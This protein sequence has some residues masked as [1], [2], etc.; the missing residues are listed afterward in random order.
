M[1]KKEQLLEKIDK[2]IHI[3][4]TK[5]IK[6]IGEAQFFREFLKVYDIN[7]VESYSKITNTSYLMCVLMAEDINIPFSSLID[8]I[9]KIQDFVNDSEID[10]ELYREYLQSLK[11]IYDLGIINKIKDS[12]SIKNFNEEEEEAF[13]NYKKINENLFTL[14]DKSGKNVYLSQANDG[15]IDL[16]K[17]LPQTDKYE[18]FLDLAVAPTIV[19]SLMN[20][21]YDNLIGVID[22]EDENEKRLVNK[23]LKRERKKI[24]DHVIKG[25]LKDYIGQ[26]MK[27]VY[28]H[29]VNYSNDLQKQVKDEVSSI[30][31]RIRKFDTFI[32]KLKYINN[33]E[34]INME[35][36]K[37]FLFEEDIKTLF[38]EFCLEQN[39]SVYK[40]I[41]E[42]NKEYKNNKI[43]KVEMAFNKY[44]FNFNN[45]LI[46]EQE[47]IIKESETKNIE[48]LLGII[49]YSDLLFLT[50][51]HKEFTK[52]LLD[53]DVEIFR[54]VDCALKNKIIDKKFVVNNLDLLFNKNKYYNFNKNINLLTINEIDLTNI[55]KINPNLL[56]MD[57]NILILI[58]D[59][60]KE[61]NF[62]LNDENNFEIL[63]NSSLLDIID[64][65]IELGIEPIIKDNQKYLNG[66]SFDIVKRILISNLIGM[67]YINSSNKLVGQITTGN[68]FY[69]CPNKYDNYIVNEEVRYLNPSCVKSLENSNRII[70][71]DRLK[72]SEIIARLDENYYKDN[73]TY[74]I[75]G[76][77]I[78]RNRVL[79]NLEV[80]LQNNELDITD[81]IYQAI[82]YKLIGNVEDTKL[83]EIYNSINSL[84]LQKNK[85]YIK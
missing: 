9:N 4:E 44:G 11:K 65:F 37:D 3:L 60:L 43:N 76:V 5:E 32:Y 84:N 27:F 30:N 28:D 36:Y 47:L 48:D 78:S 19:D 63:M 42:K 83:I 22:V 74:E 75:E 79:R 59:I 80:I 33:K 29:L 12:S 2:H 1:N 71:S 81:A 41:E 57:N 54:G 23:V 70:I 26:R 25:F 17:I 69:V 53:V 15:F 64:N 40:N 35:N 20:E 21:T 45:L 55:T 7:N 82:I 77:I 50:E 58:F 8:N 34:I 31:K 85:I 14:E 49:K 56:M 6:K 16:F 18:C 67:N 61:Y 66:K 46:E 51:Y 72:N 52:L 13:N 62:K 73:L 39:L 10:E 68:K 38:L 24:M